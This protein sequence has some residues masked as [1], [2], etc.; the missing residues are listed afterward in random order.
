MQQPRII[1]KSDF[2]AF[3]TRVIAVSFFC[4][5]MV[6]AIL[7]T[8]P[9]SSRD[10][11]ATN[12]IDCLFTATSATCVTGLIVFDTYLKWS[13]FGQTVILILI[14]IGG[15]GLVTLT[16]FFNVIVGRKLGLRGL[17]LAQQND[18]FFRNLIQRGKK[19]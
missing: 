3:P 10:G 19:V 17:K 15:L 16:T 12:F 9:I 4:V 5:I 14:Q 8:L 2:F 13:L 11:Q 7:L 1:K 18:L 6:G